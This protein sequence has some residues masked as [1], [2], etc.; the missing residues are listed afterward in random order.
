MRY[1][2]DLVIGKEVSSDEEGL[3]LPDARA[4]QE[5]AALALAEMAR[6]L[7]SDVDKDGLRKIAVEVRDNAGLLMTVRFDFEDRTVQ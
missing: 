7:P 3:E 6:E 4:A 5:E 1:Y 2:F